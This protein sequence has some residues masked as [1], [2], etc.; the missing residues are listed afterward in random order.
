M[1]LLWLWILAAPVG[2]LV[3]DIGEARQDLLTRNRW[4]PSEFRERA[5]RA[6]MIMQAAGAAPDASRRRVGRR[7]VAAPTS[8]VPP[9]NTAEDRSHADE[10]ARAAD[11]DVEGEA[12]SAP[13][14]Q[15]EDN[16]SRSGAEAI[17]EPTGGVAERDIE[18]NPPVR[19]SSAK[20]DDAQSRLPRSRKTSS[21]KSQGEEPPEELE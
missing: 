7:A 9:A 19:R 1:A 8:S 2:L 14:L 15:A 10:T 17:V 13:L 4:R 16:A 5:V 21:P 18:A 3:A 11:L 12:P 6:L 20:S